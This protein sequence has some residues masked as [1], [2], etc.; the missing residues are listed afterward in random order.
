MILDRLRS[1]LPM[2]RLGARTTGPVASSGAESPNQ[3]P[4]RSEK[5]EPKHKKR[6][7]KINM[8][9]KNNLL[10]TTVVSILAG[11][12]LATTTAA[13]A[14]EPELADAVSAAEINSPEALQ[15]GGSCNPCNPCEAACNPCNPCAAACNPCNPCAAACN[16]C[17]PCAAAC[18]PCN[19][20]A[21]A[22]DPCNPC[23]PCG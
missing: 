9:F 2:L 3:A 15:G 10:S 11:A 19:P 14:A 1:G 5:P 17:N 4:R 20:C 21:A 23:N 7:G 18:N 16:P 8:S 6:Q 12:S 22:N 13:Q